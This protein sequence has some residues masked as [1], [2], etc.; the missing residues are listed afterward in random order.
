MAEDKQ[1]RQ[2][3][4]KRNIEARSRNNCSRAKAIRIK[5]PECVSVALFIQHAKRM[6]CIIL[7]SAASP[8]LSYFSTLS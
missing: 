2:C 4:Y 5:Y 8:A 3:M 7:S 1:D 6:R